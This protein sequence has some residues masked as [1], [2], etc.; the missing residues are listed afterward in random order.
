[1]AFLRRKSLLWTDE[2]LR[3]IGDAKEIVFRVT[4]DDTLFV[5][6]Y[7]AQATDTAQATDI[8]RHGSSGGGKLVRMS[9]C[10]RGLGDPVING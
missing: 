7:M 5:C 1:M 10:Q 6:S 3:K 9:A 8:K 4:R 2:V